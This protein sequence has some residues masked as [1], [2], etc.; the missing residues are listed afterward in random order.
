MQDIEGTFYDREG[1]LCRVLLVDRR[2]TGSKITIGDDG[3]YFAA[4]TPVEISQDVNSTMDE[5][6]CTSATI[7]LV[8]DRYIPNLFAADVTQVAV[9]IWRGSVM[10]FAGF[11]EPQAYD[12]PFASVA[13]D[14][15]ISCIDV[16]GALQYKNY[17]DVTDHDS[18][19]TAVAN[20][21]KLQMSEIMRELLLPFIEA[22][23]QAAD[24]E[25]TDEWAV[26]YDGSR[27]LSEEGEWMGCLNGVELSEMLLMGD[28]EDD[29]WSAQDVIKEI[30]KFYT[31]HM[32]QVG[33]RFYIFDWRYQRLHT[34]VTWQDM[35]GNQTSNV[36]TNPVQRA[37]TSSLA[38]GT[39]CTMTIG[40]C[41]NRIKLTCTTADITDVI[42]SPLDSEELSSPYTSRQRYFT[43]I[44]SEGN[45]KTARTAFSQMLRNGYADNNYSEAKFVDWYMRVRSHQ[46]WRFPVLGDVNK[47]YVETYC[48]DNKA[49]ATYPNLLTKQIGAGLFSFGKVETK[50]AQNDDELPSSIDMSDMLIVS[51]NG[52]AEV[53]DTAAYPSDGQLKASIPVAVYTGPAAG[54]SLSPAD[55]AATNYIVI[56]G[57]L[58]LNPRNHVAASSTNLYAISDSRNNDKGRFYLRR[59]YT[60][61]TPRVQE[62]SEG[63]NADEL[64]P[65][66][67]GDKKLFKYDYSKVIGADG[68]EV[69]SSKDKVYKF[70]VL[71]CMLRVGGKVAV[72][73]TTNGETT[74]KVGSFQWKD[75]KPKGLCSSDDEYYSQCI[76]IGINPKIGDELV[77]TEFDICNNIDYHMGLENVSGTAIPVTK[78]D[79][80]SGQVHFEILGPVQWGWNQV[81]RRH[82]TWFRHTKWSSENVPVLAYCSDIILTDFEVKVV[83]DNGKVTNEKAQDYAY[84][85][86][87]DEGY[88]NRMDDVEFKINSD[89]TAKESADMGFTKSASLSTPV[90]SE[91]GLPLLYIYDTVTGKTAK[92]ENIYLDAVYEEFKAPRVELTLAIRDTLDQSATFFGRYTHPAFAGY[93]FLTESITRDLAACEATIKIKEIPQ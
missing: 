64:L 58:L 82:K 88:N 47:D 24:S 92:P 14:L 8:T 81:T 62:T 16:L 87:T 69:Y 31:L 48:Q 17:K 6:L 75:Y 39:D 60:S 80:V 90:L 49:Q 12:Q 1:T 53:H 36:V 85:S 84:Y 33:A 79:Q 89:L 23:G 2:T 70:P 7:N 51:V 46:Y 18:Y 86:D 29:V 13:D 34:T 28:S 83:G 3:L 42:K 5:L 37:I 27:R 59:R 74:G 40:E 44:I 71:A 25:F 57:K 52:N 91:T 41:Y 26:W 19:L 55:E 65:D 35:T 67:A 22:L 77:G 10:L 93:K 61:T 9:F 68:N 76:Y 43:E 66:V 45:G 54:I 78:A 63:Y 32:V 21:G 15:A 56:S 11:V 30:L 50:A 4:D 72:E 73:E 38:A 20:T